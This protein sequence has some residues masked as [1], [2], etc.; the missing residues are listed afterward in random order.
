M[1]YCAGRT[2]V[3]GGD[4]AR[5]E[6]PDFSA[7]PYNAL[8]GRIEASRRPVV[9]ALHGTVLGGGLELAMACHYRVAQPATR[10]GLPEVKL[11]LLPGSLGTQ[12]LPRLVGA[13]LALDMILSGRMITAQ[14]ALRCRPGRRTEGWRAA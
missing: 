2:F 9:A 10:L 11:G 4:I 13:P 8:L 14:Q 7:S 3:A 5:F 1:L 12:R 6:L